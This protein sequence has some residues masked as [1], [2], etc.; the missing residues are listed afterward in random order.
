MAIAA[1]VI[2]ALVPWGKT[3]LLAPRVL[4]VVVVVAASLCVMTSAWVL[5]VG[6]RQRLAEVS[7]IGTWFLVLS[8][9]PLVHGLTT[10]GVLYGPNE[11]FAGSV[12][13]SGL[14]A[15]AAALPMLF[16]ESRWANRLGRRSGTWVWAWVAGLTIL[17]AVLLARPNLAPFPAMGTGIAIASSLPVV[18][19][20]M[21]CSWRC[22][23][24]AAISGSARYLTVFVGFVFTGVAQLVWVT[25]VAFG[26]TFWFAH[27]FDI[28]G[29]FAGTIGGAW[30]YM[31]VRPPSDLVG[32]VLTTD[33][34]VALDLAARP[35]RRRLHR[36]AGCQGT[37]SP[38]ITY[39]GQP[40]RRCRWR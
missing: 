33:P 27:F 26:P 17:G 34:L 30:A 21:L 20:A 35:V 31:K 37:R 40:R 15:G 13:L 23:T 12:F 18:G 6:H 38:A 32:P 9:L 22:L 8:V 29:V 11:V 24:M 16:R 25:A 4:F 14:L 36:R 10:P 28:S 1:M 5:W 2:P 19:V 3:V 7:F 39:C